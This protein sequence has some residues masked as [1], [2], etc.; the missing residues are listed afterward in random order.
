MMNL[1][2][3]RKSLDELLK[4]YQRSIGG[5][6][7]YTVFGCGAPPDDDLF[8]RRKKEF[9]R[10]ARHVG[11]K[12]ARGEEVSISDYTGVV[13]KA[14]TDKD[15]LMKNEAHQQVTS[16]L[17]NG[18]QIK[19][20]DPTDNSIMKETNLKLLIVA[21]SQFA[22]NKT[23]ENE[24]FEEINSKILETFTFV[25]RA[26]LVN[27]ND[28]KPLIEFHLQAIELGV[29]QLLKQPLYQ[30]AR[31]ALTGGSISEAGR[32][33]TTPTGG[34]LI[35]SPQA[36]AE[37]AFTSGTSLQSESRRPAKK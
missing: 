9:A 12:L 4:P 27:D 20:I 17:C 25:T 21:L 35:Q 11:N 30:A 18:V 28:Y 5:G 23:E 22:H 2:Q 7:C 15:S 10:I 37:A 31:A 36:P 33:S 26:D 14:P 32:K 16:F 13:A 8:T 24:I 19:S 1:E 3:M 6:C 29:Y 34:L